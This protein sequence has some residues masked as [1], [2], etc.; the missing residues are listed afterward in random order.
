[1]LEAGGAG[2]ITATA[3][4]TCPLAGDIYARWQTENVRPLQEHLT[5]VRA[6]IEVYPAIPALKR[7]MAEQ[8]GRKDWLHLRPPL[9]PLRDDEAATL[10]DTLERLRFFTD[11]SATL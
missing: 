10:F 6:A 4:V 7:I 2:C 5:A 9:A 11:N 3:N 1:M 8:S